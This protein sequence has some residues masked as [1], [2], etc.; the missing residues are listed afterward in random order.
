MA[1][2]IKK[3]RTELKDCDDL[4]Y[5]EGTCPT[6]MAGPAEYNMNKK[7]EYFTNDTMET[8]TEYGGHFTETVIG[9][10]KEQ[11]RTRKQES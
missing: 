7:K 8:L 1:S 6:E 5:S 2:Y 11:W 4:I 3:K 9:I 10:Q